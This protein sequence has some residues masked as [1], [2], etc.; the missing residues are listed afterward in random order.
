MTPLVAIV[1]RPNTGKSTLFNRIA[2]ARRALVDDMPGL[3]RDVHLARTNIGGRAVLLADTGGLS[4]E[5]GDELHARVVERVDEILADADAVVFLLDG[6]E[7]LLPEDEEIAARLRRTET[8]VFHVVNKVEGDRV[9][10]ASGEFYRL[11][12]NDLYL[13]SAKENLGVDKL[14]RKIAAVLPP[15]EEGDAE[16]ESD[17]KGGTRIAIVGKPNVGKSSLVNRMIGANRMIVSEM[18][19]TTRDAIDVP[20][21]AN[22]RDYLLI[23]T[24]GIRRKAKVTERVEKFSVVQALKALDRCH[25]A[26]VMGDAEEFFSDQMLRVTTYAIDRG[27]A[28][29]WLFNKIDLVGDIDAWRR[30]IDRQRDFRL[31]HLDFIPML[32][33]SAKTGRGVKKIMPLVTRVSDAFNRRIETGPLNRLIEKAIQTHTPPIVKNR[34]L[35]FYYATQPTVRPPSFVM[36]ANDPGAVH[37]SYHRFLLRTIRDSADFL[38]SP[39]RL[40]IKKRTG[41][42]RPEAAAAAKSE[43][44]RRG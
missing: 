23:D 25:I 24:A 16:S 40:S 35:K 15:A 43:R 34:Q 20:F 1:G 14:L 31:R 38:G 42:A 30:E 26:L 7:G 33:I 19:G 36:F 28:V 6:R 22:G 5:T 32:E 4:S 39:V 3:T 10:N 2:G 8:P 17:E 27:R 12:A 29:V 13:I 9:A 44:K 11:G 37:F 21:A 18:P 41:A